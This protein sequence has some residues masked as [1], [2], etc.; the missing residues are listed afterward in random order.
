M[1]TVIS[2]KSWT[3]IQRRPRCIAEAKDE[4]APLSRERVHMH[5]DGEAT[6]AT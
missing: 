6:P 5:K 3:S 2:R 4:M 1:P